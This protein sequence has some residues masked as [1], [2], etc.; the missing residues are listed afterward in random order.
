MALEDMVL[1]SVHELLIEIK[2]LKDR[3]QDITD[4]M[5]HKFDD[6]VITTVN[7]SSENIDAKTQSIYDRINKLSDQSDVSYS[8]LLKTLTGSEGIG[9]INTRLEA[10]EKRFQSLTTYT[11]AAITK[12]EI[13]QRRSRIGTIVAF[14]VQAI[15]FCALAL[16]SI[17]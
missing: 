8:K 7:H 16:G 10:I 6:Q 1:G 2:S 17:G 12:I 9:G 14:V 13:R 4:N 3:V 15:A 11:S 5:E